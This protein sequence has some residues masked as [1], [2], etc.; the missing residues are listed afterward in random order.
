MVSGR[1]EEL[2][3]AARPALSVGRSELDVA[4]SIAGAVV[5]R[6]GEPVG[7]KVDRGHTG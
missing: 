5:A 1:F 6:I 3:Q 7:M 2:V 4:D